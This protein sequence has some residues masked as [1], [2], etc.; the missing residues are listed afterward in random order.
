MLPPLS[1]SL[2]LSLSLLFILLLIHAPPLTATQQHPRHL[3]HH[4]LFTSQPPLPSPHLHHSLSTT[5]PFSSSPTSSASA[6]TSP[7]PSSSATTSSD[8]N[9]LPFF[10]SYP[11]PPPPPPPQPPLPPPVTAIPTFPA[12]V[13]S[14]SLPSTSPSSTDH[15][16]SKLPLL[17]AIIAAVVIVSLLSIA[18]LLRRHSRRP[19]PD[20]LPLYPHPGPTSDSLPPPKTSSEFLYLGTVADTSSEFQVHPTVPT[21]ASLPDAVDERVV[22]HLKLCG[23]SSP[24]LRP[25]PP[26]PKHS[27]SFHFRSGC[28]GEQ[29]GASEATPAG[30]KFFD[31]EEFFSPSHHD[32]DGEADDFFNNSALKSCFSS[33]SC[34]GSPCND[35]RSDDGD[36][37]VSVEIVA[38]AEKAEFYPA[39]PPP[40]PQPRASHAGPPPLIPPSGPVV[41]KR[42][43]P[44]S[45]S[46]ER[47]EDGGGGGMRPKL[48]ALYWDK[49]RASSDRVTVWDQLHPG[50]FKLNEEMIETLFTA[51][52]GAKDGGVRRSMLPLLNEEYRVLDPKKS[53]NIAIL[54]K[55]LSVTEKE[56]CEALFEGNADALGMELLESLLKMAP[57]K[58]EER[59]LL[60]YKDESPM[61]LGP[62]EKF[63]R[64]LLDVPFAFKRVDA[65]LY[66]T[67]FDSEVEYLRKA[68]EN[69][70]AACKQLRNNRMF[71]KLLEAV[72]KTGNRMNVGTNRGDAEAFKLDTLLKLVDIKGRDGKT[73]LLHFVVQEIIKAE[74]C[75]N[76]PTGSDPKTGSHNQPEIP[77]DIESRKRGLAIVASLGG[78]LM[79]VKKAAAMDSETLSTDVGKLA[80]GI[81]KINEVLKLSE[82]N[83]IIKTN[84]RFA[85]AMNAFSK[86]AEIEII[87]IQSQE[88]NAF[89][90]VKELTEYFHGNLSKE[91]AHP[92][93]IFTVVRD[94]LGVLD[95]VCKEVG[96]INE[97]TIMSSVRQ[98]PTTSNPALQPPFPELSSADGAENE[99]II[100]S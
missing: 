19:S 36:S 2:S 43:G 71:L 32:D 76:S 84:K 77:D 6:T 83:Q 4:P 56:V 3:L 14:L 57:T 69:L 51:N 74:G 59:K 58:E 54:L 64:A 40:P 24:E 67:S 88:S 79:N 90:K 55:A 27:G 42:S 44:L 50:S 68:F 12:N 37:D 49:V 1:L 95:Q 86:K 65:M 31:N 87:R 78:E 22:Y 89:A 70:E 29:E 66:M 62:A 34:R 98:F 91:E 81:A 72:L 35:N 28:V 33:S 92:F 61:K 47:V 94:F 9:N 100:T 26:L 80:R 41:L 85:D 18:V 48:K 39:P 15:H 38:L 60:E 16:P 21:T 30:E 25:L 97:R 96:K 53:Q 17:L 73:T 52:N 23:G 75:R 13:S 93:R 63:L 10:P 99:S 45:K 20:L 7:P 82:E 8:N 5:L 46:G 11:S